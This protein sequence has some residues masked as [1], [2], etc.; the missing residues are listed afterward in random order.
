MANDVCIQTLSQSQLAEPMLAAI[1]A[2][3][4]TVRRRAKQLIE[5]GT[6]KD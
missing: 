4:T 3:D 5:N 6:P 1:T 2:A